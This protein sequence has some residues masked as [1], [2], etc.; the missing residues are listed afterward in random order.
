MDRYTEW[1]NDP[2]RN[3]TISLLM[4][5][6]NW[7]QCRG[8]LLSHKV[9]SGRS[10]QLRV[11]AIIGE[12]IVGSVS[13]LAARLRPISSIRL[14]RGINCLIIVN[15]G[16]LDQAISPPPRQF[17]DRNTVPPCVAPNYSLKSNTRI[18][19]SIHLPV[20]NDKLKNPSSVKNY[21]K[22]PFASP[23]MNKIS[24]SI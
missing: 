15:T 2:R 16:P 17:L 13:A 23:R 9:S 12:F 5:S 3:G 8:R 19:P 6:V 20:P 24:R 7:R 1:S 14:G 10:A 21:G 11:R 22:L 4:Q 18:H